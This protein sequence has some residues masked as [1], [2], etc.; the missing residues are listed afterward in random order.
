MNR[1]PPGAPGAR[2]DEPAIADAVLSDVSPDTW[3]R[4]AEL[5]PEAMQAEAMDARIAL[6]REFF[7]RHLSHPVTLQFIGTLDEAATGRAKPGELEQ[8]LKSA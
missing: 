8:L 7:A 5:G 6:C 1:A 4:V 3:R 2:I